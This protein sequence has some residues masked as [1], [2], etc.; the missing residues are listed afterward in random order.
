MGSAKG[1]KGGEKKRQEMSSRGSQLWTRCSRRLGTI[2]SFRNWKLTD[3]HVGIWRITLQHVFFFGSFCVGGR[4]HGRN[5]NPIII[6]RAIDVHYRGAGWETKVEKN[7][8]NDMS[9][10]LR[11]LRTSI[12]TWPKQ[13]TWVCGSRQSIF[14][15]WHTCTSDFCFLLCLRGKCIYFVNLR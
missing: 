8:N 7:T 14:N 5:Q 9:L 3:H 10:L 12:W 11:P 4:I 1:S 2:S 13:W 6:I 15:F